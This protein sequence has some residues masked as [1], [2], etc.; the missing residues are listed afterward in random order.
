[1]NMESR[2]SVATGTTVTAGECVPVMLSL[3]SLP[4]VGRLG[5]PTGGPIIE[6]GERFSKGPAL[7]GEQV[8]VPGVL[9]EVGLSKLAKPVGQDA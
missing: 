7:F 1:M 6:W 8:P 2:H 4:S 3:A 9:D 5:L